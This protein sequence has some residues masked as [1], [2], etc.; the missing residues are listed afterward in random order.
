MDLK[1]ILAWNVNGYTNE[2]HEVVKR[3]I[4]ETSPVI[5]FL[6]ETKQSKETLGAYFGSINGY[7]HIVNPHEPH[8]YHGVAMLIREDLT[9][10]E[11]YVPLQVACRRDSK[12]CKD[13]CQGRVIAIQH[14][15]TIIIG[16]Y[17]P[18]SGMNM[19]KEK[20]KLEYRVNDWDPAFARVLSG[21]RNAGREV[22]WIGDANVA[23]TLALDISTPSMKTWAGCRPGERKNF[24]ALMNEGWID[25]WR[26]D[27]PSAREYTWRGKKDSKEYGMRIDHIIVTPGLLPHIDSSFICH[28]CPLSDHVPVG[29]HICL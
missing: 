1:C 24:E 13:A 16:A 2:K 17:T 25:V 10:Q 3:I 11:M 4:R 21:W 26:H 29:M 14:N 5:V 19:D 15:N 27:H 23:P 28:S 20:H 6:T 7:K 12:E 9:F 18:N 22:I 8:R